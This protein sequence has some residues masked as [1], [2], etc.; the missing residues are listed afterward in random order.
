[1]FAQPKIVT[2]LGARPQFIKAAAVSHH[3][4]KIFQEI[5]IHTGQHYDKQMSSI[6]FQDLK[7]PAPAY[8]LNIQAKN[9]GE[10]TGRMLIKIEEILFKEKPN[11]VLLYGDTNSTLAGALAAAKLNIP[12]AHVEAGVRSHNLLMPEE[13][14]RILTD[15]LAHW[16]FIPSQEARHHLLREGM[17]PSTIHEVGDV[18]YDIFLQQRAFAKSF[19]CTF[20]KPY[21]LVTL[22]RAENFKTSDQIQSLL[23]I[24]AKLTE[25][26]DILWPI[27]PR[28]KNHQLSIPYPL[29]PFLCEPLGYYEMIYAL[30]NCYGVLTDSGGLQKEAY[31]ASKPCVT[32]RTET[33]WTELVNIGWN[34]VISPV[35]KN[36]L[37]EINFF[38]SREF[39]TKAHPDLY[40]QG[41]AAIKITKILEQELNFCG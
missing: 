3:L 23:D 30:E 16:H 37:Q 39:T 14:N 36:A 33:E 11:A 27:H 6:F 18:M 12:I 31:Y 5:I 19:N 2:I 7:I 40:G 9:H 13:I 28:L 29:L 10:M 25:N 22:H 15:R 26:Y 20:S 17:K 1:M 34:K 38:L 41:N 4:Q 35:S 24:L 21:L 32:L 8:N